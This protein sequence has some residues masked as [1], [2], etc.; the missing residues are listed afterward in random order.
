M[1]KSF[2]LF[3]IIFLY[4]LAGAVVSYAYSP[5]S[6]SV[7]D[8]PTVN[9]NSQELEKSFKE[10]EAA[11]KKIKM[12]YVRQERKQHIQ[13]AQQE[14]QESASPYLQRV[15]SLKTDVLGD[16]PIREKVPSIPPV[17]DPQT[18][19]DLTKRAAEIEQQVAALGD[20]KNIAVVRNK[21]IKIKAVMERLKQERT[22]ALKE[23][24]MHEKL[25]QI[26]Q[27]ADNFN[28]EILKLT[29]SGDYAQARKKYDEFQQA[30]V[31]DFG[32]LKQSIARGDYLGSQ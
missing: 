14:N 17:E 21:L 24:Y 4:P 29:Q 30:M 19:I 31:D 13:D 7:A 2:L 5:S 3:L 15:P 16:K 8:D 20:D 32:R 26:N 10:G 27:Q 12:E 11:L 9:L 25:Y 22:A 6:A 23:A 18:V 1:Q 28:Q